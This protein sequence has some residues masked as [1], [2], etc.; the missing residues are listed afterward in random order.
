MIFHWHDDLE[1]F[2]DVLKVYLSGKDSRESAVRLAQSLIGEI[3]KELSKRQPVEWFSCLN[4]CLHM[5]RLCKNDY[6][7][8]LTVGLCRLYAIVEGYDE[9]DDVNETIEI[10]RTAFKDIL[11][12]ELQL[13]DHKLIKDRQRRSVGGKHSSAK[14]LHILCE[15]IVT[16]HPTWAAERDAWAHFRNKQV[17][18]ITTDGKERVCVEVIKANPD[19]FMLIRHMR[20]GKEQRV[21]FKTFQNNLSEAR[22]RLDLKK[23]PKN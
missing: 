22:K 5:K 4:D 2:L 16:Y 10:L 13:R 15:S 17:D 6:E 1:H 9:H 11:I 7:I 23:N 12:Q 20:T 14:W 18:L 8:A 19:D 21:S 3:N